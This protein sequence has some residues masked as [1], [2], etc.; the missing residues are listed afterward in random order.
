MKK[1]L[2]VFLSVIVGLVVILMFVAG[3]FGL[4]APTAKI[5]GTDKPKDLGVTYTEEDTKNV[6]EKFKLEKVDAPAGSATKYEGSREINETFSGSELTALVNSS[7]WAYT[8]IENVQIKVG[9]N[10]FAE[11]SGNLRID[12][13]ASYFAEVSPNIVTEDELNKVASLLPDTVP[14]YVSGNISFINGNISIDFGNNGSVL[15]GLISKVY[16][17]SI[18]TGIGEV[19]VGRFNVPQS[20]VD[21]NQDRVNN[22]LNTGMKHIKG[23]SME[24]LEF[25]NG[26]M[27]LKGTV[28]TKKYRPVK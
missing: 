16:A 24:D 12:L 23:L 21:S 10:G 9:D 8:P 17:S 22:F 4:F 7:Q 1:G 20:L 2:I 15:D 6:V 19:T 5:L 11:S 26:S 3:Y 25:N 27:R 18:S 14:Y 13:L 28:P